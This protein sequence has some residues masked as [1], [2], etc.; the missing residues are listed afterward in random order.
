MNIT[1]K[2]HYALV[3]LIELAVNQGENGIKAKDLSSNLNISL[4]FLDSVIATLKTSGLI[5][6]VPIFRIGGYRLTLDPSEINVY[7]I[8][9]SIEPE[10]KLY[11]CLIDGKDCIRSS[12][13]GSHYFL[14]KMNKEM[15][16]IMLSSTLKDL[17]E[18]QKQRV[19]I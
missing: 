7:M 16:S 8:Y 15:E 18:F 2:L 9:C 4:R 1:A 10:L 11:H 3:V 12:F 17:V 19:I 13:C 6:R 14:N 5:Y